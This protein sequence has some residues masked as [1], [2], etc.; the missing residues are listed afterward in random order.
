[1]YFMVC[2]P[3]Q[4]SGANDLYEKEMMRLKKLYDELTS[5]EE[6]PFHDSENGSD[7]N[8]SPDETSNSDSDDGNTEKPSKHIGT[9]NDSSSDS[10]GDDDDSAEGRMENVDDFSNLEEPQ[11]W[12]STTASFPIFDFDETAVGLKINI[13]INS[14]PLDAFDLLFTSQILEYI[15]QSS[16]D[17]GQVWSYSNRPKRK[18]SRSASFRPITVDEIKTFLAFGQVSTTNVRRYF[19]FKD[20]LYFHPIFPFAMSARRFELI[21]RVLC[22]APPKSKGKEKVP[23]FLDLL[24]SQ[25]QSAYGPT[26]ELF[27][28]E[29]LLHFRG[30]L[31]FRVYIKNKKKRYGIKF[32]E[33]TT[34]DGY[35][36]N[37]EMYSGKINENDGGGTKTENLVLRLMKPYL[38]KGHHLFMDNYYNSIALSEKLLNLKTHTNV[39]LRC[40]RRDNPKFLVKKELKRGAHFWV[41]KKQVYVSKWKNKRDVLLITP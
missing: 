7:P 17:Y 22:C 11:S 29:S 13:G 39:T 10:V 18:H 12:E 21:L 30:R 4:M 36:L 14:T 9:P 25:Y 31:A 35:V 37:M 41:R 2:I 15:I 19:S 26:R 1:M 27:L 6:D 28:D 16:N 20:I 32:F 23:T 24:I 34:S 5:E 40:N 38:V 33:L 3:L 8:Y